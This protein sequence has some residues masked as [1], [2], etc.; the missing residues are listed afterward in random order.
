M[1][2]FD[3]FRGGKK[4]VKHAAD[5]SVV[6]EQTFE[7]TAPPR[8]VSSDAVDALDRALARAADTSVEAI[9]HAIDPARVVAFADGGPPVWSVA[10]CACPSPQ[11]SFLY[12]TYGLARGIDGTAAFE[13]ELSMRVLAAESDQAPP[14]WPTLFLRNLARYQLSSGRELRVGDPMNF[15][16]SITRIGITPE[17]RS[18]MPDSAMT[19]IAITKDS[20]LADVTLP[21]GSPLEVRRVYGLRADEYEWLEL[22]SCDAV[23]GLVA[24][25]DAHL[26]T[27]LNRTSW[28]D[29]VNFV[30]DVKTGAAKEGSQTGALVIGNL[31]WQRAAD[32]YTVRVPTGSDANRLG[33]ML[34]ARLGFGRNLFV[35]DYEPTP[36]SQVGIEPGDQVQAEEHD[37]GILVVSMPADNQYVQQLSQATSS[38]ELHFPA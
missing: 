24:S 6:T 12:V 38:V 14:V 33:R 35:H 25:R 11:K 16:E 18:S 28:S 34:R 32:G 31:Q 20:E 7:I 21:D 13:H 30:E 5:G 26:T 27:D 29:D 22:W 2:L 17:D 37:G 3:R 4:S 23:M 9:L 1:G 10:V 19:A 36:F 8:D 15:P